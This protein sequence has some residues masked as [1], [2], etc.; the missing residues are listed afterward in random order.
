MSSARARR[1]RPQPKKPEQSFDFLSKFGAV[2]GYHVFQ[3]N[4]KPKLGEI[5]DTRQERNNVED[6][7]A[8]AVIN[9]SGS[10]VGHLPR[11]ISEISWWFLQ[12][13]GVIQVEITNPRRVF[14]HALAQGGLEI[15]CCYLYF[16]S[17][18]RM[19]KLNELLTGKLKDY[20]N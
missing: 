9:S 8:V 13:G 10:K 15:L 2:R 18:T 6:R 14:S 11:E 1:S 7:F 19:K 16:A 4:W 5:L 12:S 3:A 17:D 20:D